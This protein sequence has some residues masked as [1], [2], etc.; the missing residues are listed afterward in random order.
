[1]REDNALALTHDGCVEEVPCLSDERRPKKPYIP[2]S[3]V[4]VRNRQGLQ[5]VVNVRQPRV[6]VLQPD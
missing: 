2:A 4:C 1:M 3:A 5:L 6:G